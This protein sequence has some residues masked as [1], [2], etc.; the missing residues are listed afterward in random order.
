MSKKLDVLM[1]EGVTNRYKVLSEGLVTNGQKTVRMADGL[2]T[3][4]KNPDNSSLSAKNK[5][6]SSYVSPPA[7]AFGTKKGKV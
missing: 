6:T 3:R 5:M 4:E 7:P 2:S 1:L